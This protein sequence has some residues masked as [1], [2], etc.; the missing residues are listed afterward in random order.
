MLKSI[1][2]PLLILSAQVG[3]EPPAIPLVPGLT[4]TTAVA[5]PGGDY[6]SHKRL[7]AREGNGWR[8][9]YSASVP[10]AA[11]KPESLSN[12][13]ILHDEDMASARAYRNYFESDVEEDYPGTTA[14]GASTAVL[15]ELQS[16]GTSRFTLVGD[17]AFLKQAFA[18]TPG[19]EHSA[20][21]LAS[22]LTAGAGISFKGE[23]KRQS[24]GHM[25]V[26]INDRIQS[27]PVLVASGRFTARNGRS[28]DAEL[29]LLIDTANPIALQWRIGETRLRVVRIDYPAPLTQ[30]AQILKEEKRVALPGLYFDF[31]SATLRPE[32]AAALPAILQAVRAAPQ[33]LVLEGHTDSIGDPAVN[34]ALSLARAQAVW[35]ALR[36]LDPALAAKPDVLGYGASR[37][38]AGNDTLQGRAQNRRVELAIP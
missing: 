7:L 38:R 24:I 12:E 28:M 21:A 11:G 16:A 14:L 37:P 33:G 25:D 19:A 20:L 10:N 29:S 34:L 9:G 30:L 22:A 26:L 5:E 36:A 18:G 13:R 23:L 32:S 17:D 6:E 3:A 35:S 31:G 15:E 2:I 4:I 1:A 27:V 8:L